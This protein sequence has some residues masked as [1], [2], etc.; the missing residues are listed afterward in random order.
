MQAGHGLRSLIFLLSS[1]NTN[2]KP[3]TDRTTN[4]VVTG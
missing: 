2:T 4:F 1:H 3:K